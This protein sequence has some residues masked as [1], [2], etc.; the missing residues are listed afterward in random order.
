VTAQPT[1]AE[2]T[3]TLGGSGIA[4]RRASASLPH[5]YA[6][7]GEG[8]CAYCQLPA[9]HPRHDVEGAEEVERAGAGEP[10][11]LSQRILKRSELAKLPP[12]EPLIEDTLS[13]RSA[14]VLIGPT[15]AGKTFLALSWACSVGTGKRWLGRDITRTPVLYV[16][17][18][19]AHGLD[20]R[21]TA[22]E[23]EWGTPVSDDDVQFVIRPD[24]LTAMETW[25]EIA[26]EAKAFGA[27]MVI[28]DTFSSLA[29]DADETKDAALIMRRLSDLA[30]AI[31][32]TA[33]LV[34]HPGWSDSSRVRGGYQ[35]EA[36]ADEVLVLA[37][38][39]TPSWS[40]SPA[41]R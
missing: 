8:H 2:I 4:A 30:A 9:K 36:N 17:G 11:R 27:R 39:P 32:G 5:H 25:I 12:V 41:R 37:A 28:L 13:L 22:W 7:V 16:V 10:T 3:E 1:F 23:D 6:D 40:A 19:G 14:V 15:G 21:V 33:L 26:A 38:W 24:S 29:P 31:D 35:F 20:A 34:H 18:E